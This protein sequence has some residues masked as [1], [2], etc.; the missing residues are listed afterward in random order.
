MN[1]N[2][3]QY[4]KDNFKDSSKDDIKESITESLTKKEEV[5]LPGLG[6]LFEILWLNSDDA[7]HETILDTL[8]NNIK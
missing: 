7:M 8:S 2:I 4:I 6:C 1:I 5:T 3:R